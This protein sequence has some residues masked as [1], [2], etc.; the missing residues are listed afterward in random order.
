MNGSCP[1]GI[2]LQPFRATSEVFKGLPDSGDLELEARFEQTMGGNA[3]AF[4]DQ[5]C[6][7]SEK[8]STHLE[9]PIGG[10]QA[11]RYA[12]DLPKSF[13]HL[14]VGDG[15]GR[16]HV[17]GPADLAVLNQPFNRPAK[18]DLVNPGDELFAAAHSATET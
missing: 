12:T 5:F 8:E 11:E 2:G 15:I 13:H 7:G 10:G 1:S 4:D 3:T 18:I 17:D 14:T 6:L 9:H 16:C